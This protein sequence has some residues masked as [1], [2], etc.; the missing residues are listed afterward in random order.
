MADQEH[1][2]PAWLALRRRRRSQLGA[3]AA[4][5]LLGD[6]RARAY[7]PVAWLMP[8]G[9]VYAAAHV[10]EFESALAMT[11][12]LFVCLA[13]IALFDARFFIIPDVQVGALAALGLLQVSIQ[14]AAQIPERLLAAAAAWAGMSGVA[15]I[16]RLLRGSSGM[17]GGDAKLLAAGGLWIGVAGLPG[18]LVWAAL[19]GLASAALVFSVKGALSGQTAIPF[20]P[21][22]CLGIWFVWLFGP[23]TG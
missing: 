16:Y 15:L 11:F 2:L 13:L 19:S 12:G 3:L 18:C 17:G 22:L 20:G 4:A 14:D 23:L 1:G 21:H 5:A 8:G 6:P 10:R 9:L 7:T